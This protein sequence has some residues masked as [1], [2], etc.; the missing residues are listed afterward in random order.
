M[1][2]LSKE[3]DNSLFLFIFGSVSAHRQVWA[4]EFLLEKYVLYW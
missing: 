1:Y 2:K 4:P 3:K